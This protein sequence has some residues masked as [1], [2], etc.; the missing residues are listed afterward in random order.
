[1]SETPDRDRDRDRDRTSEPANFWATFILGVGGS[2]AL[3]G[4]AVMLGWHTRTEWLV[5]WHPT[6]VAM[7]YNTALSFL[8]LGISIGLGQLGYRRLVVGLSSMVILLSLVIGMQYLLGRDFGIDNL[9]VQHFITTKTPHPGRMAANTAVCFLFGGVALVI[10]T[11][12]RSHGPLWLGIGGAVVSG[13]GL[14]AVI[15]YLVDLESAFGWGHWTRMAIQTAITFLGLGL[16]L[17]AQAWSRE[18]KQVGGMPYWLPMQVFILLGAIVLATWLAIVSASTSQEAQQSLYQAIV[19]WFPIMGGLTAASIALLVHFYQITRHGA[20]QTEAINQQ[21]VAEITERKLVE[22]RLAHYQTHLEMLVAEQTR[23]VE[24]ASQALQSRNALFLSFV[25]AIADGFWIVDTK[26]HFIEVNDYY[27]QMIGF[28]RQELLVMTITDLKLIKSPEEFFANLAVT[29]HNGVNRFV[30]QHATKA[31]EMIPVEVSIAF[32]TEQQLYVAFLR[33]MRPWEEMLATL[34]SERERLRQVEKMEAIG[35]LTG[36]MA[37]NFNNILAIILGNAE[38]AQLNAIRTEKALDEIVKAADRGRELINHLMTF[39]RPTTVSNQLFQPEKVVM[40]A[41]RFLGSV[42]SSSVRL[43]TDICERAGMVLGDATQL[44]QVVIN[45]VTNAGHALGESGGEVKIGLR[46]WQMDTTDAQGLSVAP[47]DYFALTVQDNG[48]GM[49]REIL[50]RIFEPFFTTKKQGKGTGLGLAI[51]HG[52]VRQCQGAIAC[53]SAPGQGTQFR[54]YLPRHPQEPTKEV[55]QTLPISETRSGSKGRV[56]FVDD[57]PQFADLGRE[58]LEVLGYQVEVY[59]E[60]DRA[61]ARFQGDPDGFVTVITDQQMPGMTGME[62]ARRIRA[63]R[64]RLPIL[65]CTGFSEMV[66]PESGANQGGIKCILKPIRL[67]TLESTLNEMIA[68][69]LF[70]NS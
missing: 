53:D 31:G 27:C 45:L 65:L 7:V 5:Q 58:M 22:A 30:T 55:A 28:P 61:L 68:K 41:I 51:V 36:G 21:L 19:G 62:L 38:L 1:M 11:L 37:H 33:D 59:R 25:A 34:R 35:V 8:L 48:P 40:E 43:T 2:V 15:G 44:Q 23:E 56:L 66:T 12:V 29:R 70:E 13:F 9:F 54:I 42:L 39:S 6:L 26:G 47:G 60:P 63:L 49:T 18:S 57:E 50:D 69:S 20:W 16:G 24:E 46:P 17:I 52:V 4:W 10:S 64:P 67:H 3:M 14:T 32:N